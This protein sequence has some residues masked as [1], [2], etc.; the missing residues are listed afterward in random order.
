MDKKAVVG[1]PEV[2]QEIP[3]NVAEALEIDQPGLVISRKGEAALQRGANE[4][5]VIVGGRVQQ[6]AEDLLPGPFLFAGTG[7]GVGV[8][9]LEEQRLGLGHGAA[10]VGSDSGKRIH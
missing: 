9:Q 5:L 3:V 2:D 10:E 4:A 8:I 7:G 1:G 6:V